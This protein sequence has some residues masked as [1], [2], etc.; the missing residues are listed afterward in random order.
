METEEAIVYSIIETVE[1]SILSDDIKTDERVVRAFLKTYRAS[2]IAKASMDGLLIPDECF[3]YLGELRFDFLKSKQF[4]REMPK[5][6]RLKNNAGIV[7]KKNGESIPV[8]ASEEFA[9][10]LKNIINSKL[11]KAKIMGSTAVIFIGSK[12]KTICGDK[13]ALNS[14]L[15]DF[16][17]Q[18]IE[19]NSSYVTIDVTAVV[20]NTDLGVGYD[21]TTSPYPCPSELIDYIKSRIL[22]VEYNIILNVNSDNVTDGVKDDQT[23]QASRARTQQQAPQ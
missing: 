9:L 21:W 22:A 4:K 23:R 6:I 15:N 8:L 5:I 13:P 19:N 12:I 10:G 16:E 14:V 7:F 3:Q 18:S 17:E 2:A 20:D 1:K 11:P